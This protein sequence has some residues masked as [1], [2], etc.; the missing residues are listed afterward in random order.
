MSTAS[1]FNVTGSDFR[2]NLKPT[3]INATARI[4]HMNITPMGSTFVESLAPGSSSMSKYFTNK[5]DRHIA[6]P[7]SPKYNTVNPLSG[8]GPAILLTDS[9]RR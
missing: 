1:Q 7:L 9:N 6:A 3:K 2:N 4:E 5:K 8:G